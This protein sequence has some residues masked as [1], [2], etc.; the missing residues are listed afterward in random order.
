MFGFTVEE[1][2]GKSRRRPLVT[3]RQI[4]MYVFRE[5]TDLSYPAIAREFGG[6][7]H[8]TVI[9]AVE[10]IADA[11]EGAAPDLRPGHRAHPAASRAVAVT[12]WTVPVDDLWTT[13][14]RLWT[15]A[16]RRPPAASRRL[17]APL[18]EPGDDGGTATPAADLRRSRVRPQSTAPTTALLRSL[19]NE[20]ERGRSIAVKFRCERDVLVEALGTAGPGRRPPG[21]GRCPCCPACASRSPATSSQLTGSDLDLT[22]QVDG[23]GRAAS[24]DGVCV[25]AGPAGRR[26]R[27]GARA[28]GGHGRGRRRRGPHRR[29][30]LAV[31]RAAAAG[32]RVPA[33]ARAGGRRGHPRPRPTSPR[34]CARWCGRPAATTPGPILTGVLHGGRGRAACAWWPP[35]P[36]A[37]PC[38]TCRAR[39]CS[40]RARGARAV[41]GAGRADPAARRAP[42][43][44]RCAWASDDAT[45]EVGQRPAHH[46]ADRGRVPELPPADPGRYPNR[47]IVG[48]EPLLDA[49]RRVK[50]LA[51][52][53]TPVRLALR[54]RRP[55]AHGHHPG[56]GP[57][58]RG[59][60]TPSTRA[61][62]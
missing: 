62:R 18:W 20:R 22:I 12:R 4:G 37:W 15:T 8:T 13:V 42:T 49:V 44:S 1:L 46:P 5:L 9:H 40:A 31:R 3:A 41:P 32:R 58:P 7:D 56:R 23:D 36:T 28:R 14:R 50:L 30:A 48:Q 57:G 39:R 61:P 16:R 43:R 54:A 24:D 19:S 25:A 34:P 53:A 52:E 11:H 6:R 17:V 29:R 60:S 21:A 10:K 59:R 2:C 38:A 26:H 33:A 45:F 51:R 35:T 47:L 55:R 27:A